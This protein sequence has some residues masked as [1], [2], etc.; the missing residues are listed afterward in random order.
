MKFSE[1]ISILELEEDMDA[2][3]GLT[4]AYRVAMKKYH[5]DVTKLDEKFALEMSQLVNEAYSFLSQN[6]GKWSIAD[7]NDSNLADVMVAVYNKINHLPNITI[8]RMGVWLWVTINVPIEFTNDK[9]D[10]FEERMTKKR[11]LK[12][13]RQGVGKELKGRSFRYAPEK[14]K[15]GW[16][17]P[18]DAQSSW[19]RKGWAWSRIKSTFDGEELKTNPYGALA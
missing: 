10:T 2:V 11:G 12:A 19:K 18:E 7:G 15:W 5:P 17:S 14:K 13:F 16:H 9:D 6:I 3:T 4:S 8:D 1:A